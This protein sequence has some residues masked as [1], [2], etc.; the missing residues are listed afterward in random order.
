MQ[1]ECVSYHSD[2]MVENK[3]YNEQK[4]SFSFI[5]VTFFPYFWICWILRFTGSPFEIFPFSYSNFK[6]VQ[7]LYYL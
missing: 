4:E 1:Q 6:Y 7:Q 3:I 5:H 2:H